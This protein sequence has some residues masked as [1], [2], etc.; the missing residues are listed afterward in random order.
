[1]TKLYERVQ[2]IPSMSQFLIIQIVEYSGLGWSFE[3]HNEAFI[4]VNYSA[5]IEI[6]LAPFCNRL[7]SMG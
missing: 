4:N 3:V 5:H 2:E 7:G 1:M 6:L